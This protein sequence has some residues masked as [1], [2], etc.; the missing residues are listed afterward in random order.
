M[1]QC[2]TFK[3]EAGWIGISGSAKGLRRATLPQLSALEAFR[4][5]KAE[6]AVWCPNIFENLVQRLRDYFG[7]YRVTFPDR[8]DLTGATS[9]QRRVWETTRLI[10]Y[11]STRDYLW[12]AEQIGIPRAARAVG[13]ALA[14]NPLPVIIP[15]HRILTSNGSLGG[16]SGGTETKRWLLSLEAADTPL[17]GR[18]W[19]G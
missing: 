16:Y 15:C 5:L 18:G 3:T 2:I 12:V 10:P 6:G 14:Q 8:L 17:T 9:F 1:E 4:L 19:V 11:G 7:G 13:Q